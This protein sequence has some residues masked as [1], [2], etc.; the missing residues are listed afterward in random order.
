MEKE[1]WKG[2]EAIA[3][4]AIRAGCD[5]FF[6]YPITPQSEVPE[7]MSAHLPKA[8]GVFLQS[9]SEV[10]AINMVYGAAGAGMRAMTSSSSPGISLK[11]EGITYIAGAELPCVIVNCMR[12]GPGLGTIQPGQGD[13]YQATRGGGNGDYRNI[14]LCPSTVQESVDLMYEAFDI[15]EK[16]RCIVEIMSESG[17]GQMMEPCEYPEFR[18]LKKCD[19]G[20]DG[21]YKVKRGDFLGRDL[22]KESDTYMAKVRAMRENEQRWE[23]RYT[24]DA[25]YVF[26]A[27]G[28]PGRAVS[29][30]VEELR[31]A[32]EKVG[33]IRPITAWPYPEK[34]FAALAEK[35]PNLKGFISVETNG[36]GQMVDDVALY[37]KKY[38]MGAVP[39]YVLPYV[40]DIPKD[41]RVKADYARIKA[42]E[43]KE[44]Y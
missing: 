12:G 14:I 22:Q 39:V 43:I 25:E 4:A 1:L 11:Q 27:Y 6:G 42:G 33:Y 36:E 19:W 2:N 32:G 16:Y 34:A 9:E 15:A 18:E 13:Y 41:D 35:N 20:L 7:Y 38:G 17:L 31:A 21:T 24:E 28:L 30:V 37:A 23:A 44:V 26:V 8:G 29:G 3:E 10:A 5:C 40:C